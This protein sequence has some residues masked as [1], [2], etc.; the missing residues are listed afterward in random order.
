MSVHK[1]IPLHVPTARRGIQLM[2]MHGQQLVDSL[3]EG[4]LLYEV[5]GIGASSRN[6]TRQRR[7]RDHFVD[8]VYIRETS[9][10]PNRLNT[11]RAL[12]LLFLSL[13]AADPDWL[14]RVA[15]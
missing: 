9:L 8:L 3:L 2:R 12:W 7:V 6:Y 15:F 1:D 11:I 13:L 14:D 10:N 4:G 5:R